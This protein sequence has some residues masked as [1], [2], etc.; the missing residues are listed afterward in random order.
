MK[1]PSVFLSHSSKDKPFVRQLAQSLARYNVKIW[2][3]EAEINIGDSLVKKI[4][5]AVNEMDYLLVVLSE[6]S[7][8]SKWVYEE[9]EMAFSDQLS[10]DKVKILPILKDELTIPPKL[11]FILGKRYANFTTDENF[12]QD[13]P[14]LLRSIGIVVSDEKS[15]TANL[16]T[17]HFKYVYKKKHWYL[18]NVVEKC[19]IL[20]DKKY[21]FKEKEISIPVTSGDHRIVFCVQVEQLEEYN[22]YLYEVKSINYTHHFT[23]GDYYYQ[24]D[25]KQRR[26]WLLIN[27]NEPI[28]QFISHKILDNNSI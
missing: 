1:I 2:L 13:F 5:V 25:I 16:V 26:E 11:R 27:K 3:D 17:I 4:S 7:I 19:I 20:D 28:I 18:N 22:T 9:I 23:S 10:S 14:V 12:K 6:H 8:Q 15:V 21:D 24:C